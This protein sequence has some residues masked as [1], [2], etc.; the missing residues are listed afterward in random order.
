MLINK[1]EII[2]LADIYPEGWEGECLNM[3]DTP[4]AS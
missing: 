3:I 2:L 1:R 4:N